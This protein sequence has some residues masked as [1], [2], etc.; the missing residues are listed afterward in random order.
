MIVTVLAPAGKVD[1]IKQ[2]L[3][4][5]NSVGVQFEYYTE[6][7]D[8]FVAIQDRGFYM[9]KLVI[10]ATILAEMSDVVRQ[11]FVDNLCNIC[12]G[13]MTS[14]NTTKGI[15]MVDSGKLFEVEYH[16]FFDPYPMF[17]YQTQKIH[18]SQLFGLIA[19]NIKV[20]E[21]KNIDNE[22][23]KPGLFSRMFG[24]KQNTASA[25]AVA[26]E[27]AQ[28]GS[29]ETM[30]TQIQDT[31]SDK[32]LFDD[33][34]YQPAEQ[35]QPPVED[36][37]ADDLDIYI[38]IKKTEPA[39]EPTLALD[40]LGQTPLF[41][42][43]EKSIPSSSVKG[44]PNMQ[45]ESQPVQSPQ[46]TPV[47][48]QFIQN[49]FAQSTQQITPVSNTKPVKA[50][51]SPAVKPVYIDF[52]KKRSKTILFT[53]DRRSG[54][55]TVVSNLAEQASRDGLYVLV[56]DLDHDRRGQSINFPINCDPND[57]RMTLSLYHA[58]KNASNISDYAIPLNDNLSML[59]TSMMAEDSTIMHQHCDDASLRS[60]LSVAM[61]MYD[62]VLIDC[63]FS[64]LKEYSCLVAMSNYIIHSMQTDSRSVIN[65]LNMLTP[66]CFSNATDY[67]I[68]MSRVLLL[69]NCFKSHFNKGTEI[70][71][72]TVL[73]Y[74]MELTGDGMYNSL[75]V[76][77]RIPEFN[78][79]DEYMN[80]GKLLVMNSNH[81]KSF[82]QLWNSIAAKG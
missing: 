71:E 46:P 68:Y 59:G 24:R 50:Q 79:Y 64:K 75:S 23:K 72:K 29:V 21:N 32:S 30:D 62:L 73:R 2:G 48:T 56:I 20:T 49:P 16:R 27:E 25:A 11:S 81:C 60:L 31:L 77:G 55:S 26:P 43:T 57:V 76:I 82:V 74:M 19:G 51:V 15:L 70:N 69:L 53:G 65:N 42:D 63:P 22:V 45:T 39:S 36:T 66:D 17:V 28:T 18:P 3:S 10:I 8:L 7:S 41:D 9:D 14:T 54:V 12:E 1:A 38:N 4:A 44:G 37:S 6:S 35:I 78:D 40:E 33:V 34:E 47:L 58:I 67:S 5:Q 61:G 80:N 52:F 13:Y